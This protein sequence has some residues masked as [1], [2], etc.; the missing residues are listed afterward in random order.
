MGCLLGQGAR[1]ALRGW[2]RT[3]GDTISWRQDQALSATIYILRETGPT[4]FLLKEEGET[5]KIKVSVEMKLAFCIWLSIEKPVQSSAIVT[6]IYTSK[7]V[8][9]YY[10][11][12][13]LGVSVYF[14][15]LQS[16]KISVVL[17]VYKCSFTSWEV[18]VWCFASF[19]NSWEVWNIYPL[20]CCGGS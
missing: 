18:F 11:C 14:V 1:M 2:K 20:N 12:F 3:C 13:F 7:P 15:S 4:G 19:C 6:Y 17:P 9:R 8:W 16:F 5:K 10:W